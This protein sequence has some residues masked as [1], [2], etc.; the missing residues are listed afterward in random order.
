MTTR[1]VLKNQKDMVFEK[2]RCHESIDAMFLRNRGP[3]WNR[4]ETVLLQP[5]DPL[6]GKLFD[7][8]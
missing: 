6:K 1:R 5:C 2:I 7:P 4:G 8:S 3:T